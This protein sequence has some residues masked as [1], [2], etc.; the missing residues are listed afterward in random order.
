MY[1]CECIIAH[2]STPV[3]ISLFFCVLSH[4]QVQ[5]WFD[6]HSWHIPPPYVIQSFIS[7][8]VV[9]ILSRTFL[10]FCN[11]NLF[12]SVAVVDAVFH[13]KL[14][15]AVGQVRCKCAIIILI[16]FSDFSFSCSCFLVFHCEPP[17]SVGKV[18]CKC[19]I[20][21]LILFSYFSFSL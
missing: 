8:S 18:R 4:H 14:P 6:F 10:F 11:P 16:L 5:R 13:C 7:H 3:I 12:F 21:I 1:V 9:E 20:V 15:R 17:R 19:T 2:N